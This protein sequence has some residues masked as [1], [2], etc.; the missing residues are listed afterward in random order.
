MYQPFPLLEV[1]LKFDASEEY[2]F[3]TLYRNTIDGK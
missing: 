2:I 3:T 1:N